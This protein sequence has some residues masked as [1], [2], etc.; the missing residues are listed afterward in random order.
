VLTKRAM[1]KMRKM[2]EKGTS[3]RQISGTVRW[4]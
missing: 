4:D 2:I 3:I 1:L